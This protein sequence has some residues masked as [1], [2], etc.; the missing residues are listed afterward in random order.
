MGRPIYAKIVDKDSAFIGLQNELHCA[1]DAD[2]QSLIKF[3]DA[4]S[5]KFFSIKELI[6]KLVDKAS[7]TTPFTPGDES[8]NNYF[9]APKAN[10]FFNRMQ[11]M[12]H[13]APTRQ[14]LY[15]DLLS[16]L[17]LSQSPKPLKPAEQW[18]ESLVDEVYPAINE[19]YKIGDVPVKVAV[20]DTGVDGEHP[21][22]K[23]FLERKQIQCK[24]FIDGYKG[25]EDVCGHGTHAT[26]LVLKV[27]PRAEVHVARVFTSGHRSEWERNKELIASAIEHAALVWK[28]D[29]ISMSWGGREEVV[30]I[31][32]AIRQAFHLGIIMFAA[33]SNSGANPRHPVAFPASLRQVICI[34]STDAFGNLSAFNP[35]PTPDRTLSIIGEG[36]EAAWPTK[37]TADDTLLASGTSVSTPIASGIAALVLEHA[38]QLGKKGWMVKDSHRLNHCEEMRKV[39]HNM[40]RPLNGFDYII[41]AKIFDEKGDEKHIRIC[42]KILDI[43]ESL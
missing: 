30:E 15:E 13:L 33:A 21:L 19:R 23:H 18:F 25:A 2:H 22:L 43:L 37:L 17:I 3:S 31:K 24:S 7:A 4:E 20:I 6:R 36:I 16:C 32:K 1:V 28:V 9:T 29:I 34:N 11:V 40:S 5:S 38:R 14:E 27:A 39:F 8:R 42:S 41:P 26:H 10:N 12:E 35:P